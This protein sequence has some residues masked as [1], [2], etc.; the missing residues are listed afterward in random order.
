MP[1]PS[2]EYLKAHQTPR[3]PGTHHKPFLTDPANF[4]SVRS[5]QELDASQSGQIIKI[6]PPKRSPQVMDIAEVIGS[7]AVA[8]ITHSGQ[9]VFHSVGDTGIGFHEDL[10]EVVGAMRMDFDRPNPADQPSFFLH[11]GDVVYNHQYHAPESKINMYEPQFYEP[12]GNYLG[13]ILAIPGN[14]DSNPQEDPKSIDA[15]ETNFCAP[16]PSAPDLAAA[17]QM[18]KRSLMY[19]PAVYY[20]LDAP[21][22]QILALFSNGGEI[23]GVIRGSVPGHDQWNFLTKQLQE[24]KT[25]RDND[26]NQRRALII[27]VHHPPFSGGGG[28]TGSSNMLKD[29][30]AA[31]QQAGLYP[32]AVLS[33]HAHVYER[34]TREVKVGNKTMDVP[35]VVA[36]NGGHG[37]TPMKTTSDRKPIRTPL[38][39]KT[40]SGAIPADH[41]LQQYFNG[42]GHLLVTVTPSVLTIDLI[43]TRTESLTPVDRVSVQLAKD[44]ADNRIIFETPPFSHPATGE[45]EPAHTKKALA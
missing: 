35:Y 36:G 31:F 9:I 21:F 44:F 6:P 7:N 8:T 37:I 43:G 25:A 45:E 22:V 27:A 38:R 23:E 17:L 28:H 39:G 41:T 42:F 20:R 33:G 16:P 30:D 15:F 26:P 11:L 14:H 1:D 32:D 40:V 3:V 13:K 29:L 12:Y 5:Q 10:G 18:P 34:F 24:L 2:L 19:Q 4:G